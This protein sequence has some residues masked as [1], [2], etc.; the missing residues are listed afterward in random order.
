[1]AVRL[2]TGMAN[3][4]VNNQG[5]SELLNNGWLDIFTGPQPT[6]ADQVETGTKICRVSSTSGVGV[7][8]GV[9][10]GTANDGTLPITTPVWQGQVYA[11]GVAGWFRF[12]GSSGTGGV[13]GTN[14]TAI[15][16]DGAIGISGAD[17]NLTHT[18]LAA[19]SVLTLKTFY[20]SQPKQ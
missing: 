7:A 5:I 2:S 8:D 6:D 12:Y 1:M 17:L 11:D 19:G 9:K 18:N 16:M 20:I 15:R 4:L 10:F 13:T 3:A 14:G